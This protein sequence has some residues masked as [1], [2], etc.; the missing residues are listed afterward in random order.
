MKQKLVR[1]IVVLVLLA[2]VG[3]G[4]YFYRQYVEE[5]R[6]LAAMEEQR[7]LEELEKERLRKLL[8]EK[9]REFD[10]LVAAMKRYYEAGDF[11]KAREAG[12][13]ALAIAK[14]YNFET[15]EIYRIFRLMDVAENLAKLEDLDRMNSDIYKYF[16]VRTET[17]KVPDW[18]ELKERRNAVLRKTYQNEYLVKIA[19]AKENALEG[20]KG[21][22]V[23][24][25]YL[26]SR[27]HLD[28]A[29]RLRQEYKLTMSDEEDVIR[30]MQKELFLG[31]KELTENT[32][33]P[34]LY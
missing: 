9:R 21:S 29:I 27:D 23:E 6:R 5:Q 10:A 32:I 34:R 14:E 30:E 1:M 16:Y 24:F 15:D 20:K 13:K 33:P 17:L 18:Q 31:S 28:K 19:L 11:P 7:R 3:G 4:L 12:Y 8:E 25:Y 22:H 2:A 26:A